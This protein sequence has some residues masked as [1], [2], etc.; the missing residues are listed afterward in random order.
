MRIKW[1]HL[2]DIHFNYKN[3]DSHE[4][5]EDFIARINLLCEN[6]P[7]THLFLTGDILFRNNQADS[8]T[9]AFINKLI[10]ILQL[11]TE[12][13]II[14]PGNH[15]H[16][17]DIVI[18]QLAALP[19]TEDTTIDSLDQ[20]HISH[21]LT[22]FENFD[23]VYKE[24]FNSSYYTE[25]SNPHSILISDSITV[26]KLNT[27]WL[28]TD[29]SKEPSLRIGSRQLQCLLSE[30]KADLQETVNIA[31]GHHPLCELSSNERA[32]V[33]K[34]F[35][36]HNIGVYF[37]GHSHQANICVHHNYDV[38][39]IIAPGGFVDD[40]KYSIGGYVW[41]VLDTDSNFYKAEIF[42]W[43]NNKWCIDST[44]PE[45]DDHGIFYFNTSHFTNSTNIVAVDCKTM[46]G[47]V[48]KKQLDQSLGITSYDIHT[49]CGPYGN[50]SGYSAETIRELSDTI[51]KLSENGKVLH[52]YP[53]APIPMLLSLGFNLQKNTNL[54][55]HQ[56]DR[57]AD[58][59]VYNESYDQISVTYTA[60]FA[61]N[62]TLVVSIAT[63]FEIACESISAAMNRQ[64]YDY[65]EFKSNRIE[66]G[67]PL[68]NADICNIVQ[69]IVDVLNPL[70]SKYSSIHL[71][72]AIP[73]GMA[74]EL[75]RNL[76]T[77]VYK[78]IYTY[79]F[80][81]GQ[82]TQDLIINEVSP[83]KELAHTVPSFS[84]DPSSVVYIPILGRVPC[85]PVKE[86][87][88]DDAKCCPLPESILDSG[89]YF[90]L[91]A[92]GDSMIGAGIDE[93][94]YVL[95]KQQNTANE[96]EIVVAMVD[97]NT[98]IKRIHYDGDNK[99]YV[100]CPENSKYSCIPY[101]QVDIQGVVTKVIKDV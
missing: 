29:S 16:N 84:L 88:I 7:F 74:V 79:Q 101:D 100:L 94:D 8:E 32:R 85:G 82:Y 60:R 51:L 46:N 14:V 62:N 68:Y 59:W 41:G 43:K 91:E 86:A 44:L 53:L 63:S 11:P 48:P 65:L 13:V 81:Q 28:D 80:S 34:L 42:N 92:S 19:N 15:D 69:T 5:R 35:Q 55:I 22:A 1:L 49:Y 71:F 23:T 40:E 4:L 77:S 50:P 89:D 98:T 47:H 58:R 36:K 52:L 21:L 66:V 9:V 61:T 87:I 38:V 96:G 10:S 25:Y 6:E 54:L 26:T 18:S 97:G 33:L 39:E 31:V 56:H 20:A 73:A 57:K 67:Y 90:I 64:S 76:L 27:A 3:F 93:G 24:I 78:N 17:R 37:C 70:A 75:G 99:K 95:V 45:T 2:S 83:K 12:N 72:A 30:T